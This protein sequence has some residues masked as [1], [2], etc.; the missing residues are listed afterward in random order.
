MNFDTQSHK[1]RLFKIS[2]SNAKSTD[3]LKYFIAIVWTESNYKG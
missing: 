1:I 3:F 2:K